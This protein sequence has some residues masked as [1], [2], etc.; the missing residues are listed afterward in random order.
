MV[1][2][3]VPFTGNSSLLFNWKNFTQFRKAYGIK[4]LEEFDD[5]WKIRAVSLDIDTDYP[6]ILMFGLNRKDKESSIEEATELMNEYMEDHV[7][8]EL[9]E[10]II[11]SMM[12]ALVV[13]GNQTGET[14]TKPPR[15]S[16]S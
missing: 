3:E 2:R 10:L 15:Q 4:T 11:S 9:T 6:T 5:F 12:S 8:T 1:S 14:K 7:L 16:K 13:E